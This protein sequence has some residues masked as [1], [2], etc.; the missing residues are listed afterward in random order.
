[1]R[2][3]L[4][5]LLGYL[6]VGV[7]A[8]HVLYCE[9]SVLEASQSVAIICPLSALRKSVTVH[10]KPSISTTISLPPLLLRS[11]SAFLADNADTSVFDSDE[12]RNAR[13]KLSNLLPLKT[14]PS[15]S[16]VSYWSS[17][18]SSIFNAS[19]KLVSVKA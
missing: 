4:Y 9:R 6:A 3:V 2:E 8:A 15:A 18:N 12:L 14:F 5:I 1:M 11:V 7:L 10:S 13:T 17:N 16:E 19:L